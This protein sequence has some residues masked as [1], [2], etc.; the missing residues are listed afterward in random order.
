LV[1]AD[2]PTGN[3]DA[4]IEGEIAAE[5]M[6]RARLGRGTVLLATHN[7]RLAAACD[8]VLLLKDGVLEHV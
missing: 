3:L 2:E 6:A 8:R 5:L 7:D 4:A 1:L